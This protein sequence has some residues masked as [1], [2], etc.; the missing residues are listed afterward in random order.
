MKRACWRC[1]AFSDAVVLA[2]DNAPFASPG[3]VHGYP[4]PEP[5]VDAEALAATSG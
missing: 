1:V 2:T 3:G 4:Y 5:P